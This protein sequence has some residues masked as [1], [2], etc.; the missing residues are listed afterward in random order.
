[1]QSPSA[2]ARGFTLIELMIVIAIIGL[3]AAVLLPSVLGV[4]KQAKVKACEASM[5]ELETALNA[6]SRKNGYFP[7]DDLVGRD[8]IKG[9]WK[10]DN[11]QN[12]GIESM[13]LFLSQSVANG[14][15]DLGGQAEHFVN[16]DG[17]DHGVELPLLRR[18]DRIEIADPWGT[19]F[20]Y[21]AK[22]G[23]E[24][25]QQVKPA[26]EADVV[27][28]KAK[29]RDDGTAYGAGKFQLLSA[30]PDLTFGTDDDIVFPAN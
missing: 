14:G 29:R 3:L 28:V 22:G 10:P 20:V 6:F 13:L 7:P 23:M 27:A 18:R 30:G 21:F 11:G 4:S 19:P 15:T 17:D 9:N 1:M 5:L 25:P 12:I 26:A 16:T 2:A 24:K 8:R